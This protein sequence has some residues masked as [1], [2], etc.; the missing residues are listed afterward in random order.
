VEHFLKAARP[1]LES[2][3]L[4]GLR[5]STRP[6]ALDKDIL[7]ML[8]RW[9]ITTVETGVQSLHDDILEGINRGHDRATALEADRRLREAGFN[10]V[11]QLMVGLPGDTRERGRDTA[12][13]VARLKP[14][15]VRLYPAVALEGTG[16]GGMFLRGEWSPLTVD[17]AAEWCADM[18]EIFQDAG[19][20]VIRT[21]LHPLTPGEERGILAGP[22]HP[23]FGFMVKSRLAYRDLMRQIGNYIERRP[24]ESGITIALP[25]RRQGEY[26]GPGRRNLRLI[27]KTWPGHR[28][29]WTRTEES[30][31]PL[32]L[33]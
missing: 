4:T 30:G 9:G 21:G 1:F 10:R 24:E 3:E 18:T 14:E 25:A 31:S 32:I 17:E 12:R 22:Y 2:G 6:D 16:M 5:C 27:E 28:F 26:T 20:P 11:I 23:S 13:Q 15:G 8:Q 29:R 33:A 7:E 19:I